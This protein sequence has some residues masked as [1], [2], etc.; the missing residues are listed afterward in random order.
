MSS[1]LKREYTK[2][3]WLRYQ[4]ANKKR[5]TAL[6]DHF[7]EVSGLTRKHAIRLMHRTPTH[8]FK[9]RPG[10]KKLYSDHAIYHLRKL[11]VLMNQMNS[12]RLKEAL[13]S[14]LTYY[15]CT[16]A[17]KAE[18]RA[19]SAAT[20]DRKL[21]PFRARVASRR[22]TGTKP[23]SLI[24]T[25]IPIRPFDFEI[26]E[27]GHVEADT[28]AHCG[29]SLAGEFIWSLTFTDIFSG[30]TENRAV[31]GKGSAGVLDAIRDIEH[32]L[33]FVI[34][35]FNS[36]N[37]NE[38]LNYHLINYFGPEG[39]KKRHH[40]LMTRSREYKKNDNAHVEQKNWT[41]VREMFGYDRFSNPVQVELMNR[42]YREE[43]SLLH[44]FFYPQMKLKTKV[45]VG[46][47]Y[48]RTY[49][50]A[51]TP[52]QRILECEHVPQETKDKLTALFHTLNPFG[53]R[54]QMQQKLKEFYKAQTPA[55]EPQ[56]TA[57]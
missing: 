56:K 35:S 34:L 26:K 24:K 2:I 31:W 36:D 29:G 41:H 7:C 1:D 20:M 49:S 25:I 14:W 44:N 21:A 37:G 54:K 15:L 16:D 50:V 28:V 17:V 48:R 6:L 30:W 52:Y 53:L 43:H 9:K 8:W 33:P 38:F 12:K 51:K 4:N 32:K 5:K 23:G 27:P 19:M 45:R 57:A 42:T 39:E 10:R 55:P 3:L 40:Q 13:P 47:R 11:W 18:L 22:R 46:S